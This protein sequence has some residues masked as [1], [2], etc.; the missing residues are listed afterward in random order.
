MLN[1]AS[2]RIEGKFNTAKLADII[3]SV[4]GSL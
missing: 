4:K 2:S 1:F 3:N